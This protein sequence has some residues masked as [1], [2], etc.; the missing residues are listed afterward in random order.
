MRLEAAG[1]TDIQAWLHEEPTRVPA[2]ELE[3][4]LG[5]ICLGDHV[6]GMDD[7]ERSRSVHEVAERM[8]EPV[9]DYVRLDIR[10]RRATTGRSEAALAR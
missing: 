9:I 3:D 4:Y 6:E 7:Q 2:E 1:F 5:A 8:P 10:A